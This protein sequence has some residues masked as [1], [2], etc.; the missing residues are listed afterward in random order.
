M[1]LWTRRTQIW[2][3]CQKTFDRNARIFR[4][5]SKKDNKNIFQ[6]KNTSQKLPMD[7]RKQ[8]WQPSRGTFDW[9]LKFSPSMFECYEK[10]ICSDTNVPPKMFLW[11]RRLPYWQPRGASLKKKPKSFRWMTRS[12]KKMLFFFQI[13]FH[14]KNFNLQVVLNF[15]KPAREISGKLKKI[16]LGSEDAEKLWSTIKII[17]SKCSYRHLK[18]NFDKPFV[19][20]KIEFN[21]FMLQKR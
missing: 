20:Q 4:P 12:D 7:T 19:W 8:C 2:Q 17:S 18:C 13:I 14:R 5:T 3:P 9:S 6:K 21:S 10:T 11:K 1:F 15:H 16:R